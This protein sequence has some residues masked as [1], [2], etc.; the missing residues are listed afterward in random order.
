MLV[1][2]NTYMDL[3]LILV[4]RKV[5]CFQA[6]SY[7]TI[8]LMVTIYLHLVPSRYAFS[9]SY[10]FLPLTYHASITYPWNFNLV[11]RSQFFYKSYINKCRSRHPFRL[12]IERRFLIARNFALLPILLRVLVTLES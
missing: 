5:Q 8:F 6:Y 4:P 12:R 1:F 2:N 11:F 7:R 3:S 10:H 9:F